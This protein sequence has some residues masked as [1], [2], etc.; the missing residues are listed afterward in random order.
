MRC[1]RESIRGAARDA[2]ASRQSTVAACAC[3]PAPVSVLPVS[4]LYTLVHAPGLGP[5][6]WGP[7]AEQLA[8]SGQR[9]VVPSLA[10]F[11]GA[12]PPYVRRLVELAAGQVRAGPRDRVV[13]V[14]HSGSGVFAP[15]LAEAVPAREVAVIFADAAIPPGM[16]GAT[17]VGS[18]HLRFLRDLASGGMV[19]PW[20]KWLPDDVL[21]LL[22]PDEAS[23]H[24]V[25]SEARPLPL[26]FFEEALPPVPDSW[27]TCR[28]GYLRFSESYRDQA[29]EA[30]RLG[31]PVRDLPGEHLHM[32]ARPADVAAAIT[33]MGADQAG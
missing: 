14:L 29:D 17:I 1:Q 31:W 4:A 24:T 32:L 2:D 26:G 13:L 12:G 6:S 8:G 25:T 27:P 9:V 11:A 5:A 19:P 7:V 16:P 30:R 3:Y 22:F 23:C 15:Y 10:G 21:S 18:E 20:P 28:P 33:V